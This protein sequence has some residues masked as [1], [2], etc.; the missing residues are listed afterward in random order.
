MKKA[1]LLGI[2]TLALFTLPAC[3]SWSDKEANKS[4]EMA[5]VSE[6]GNFSV[7]IGDSEMITVLNG[8]GKKY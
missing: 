6:D 4:E 1:A 5:R 8:D 7:E 3:G 2:G